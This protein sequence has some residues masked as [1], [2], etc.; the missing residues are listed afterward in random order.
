MVNFGGSAAGL[1]P[2][3]GAQPEAQVSGAFD[4]VTLSPY[5]RPRPP[6]LATTA[7]GEGLAARR[8]LRI[9]T[10][11]GVAL[12]GAVLL[13]AGELAVRPRRLPLRARGAGPSAGQPTSTAPALP[14]PAP[15]KS[16]PSPS[17]PPHSRGASKDAARRAPRAVHFAITAGVVAGLALGLAARLTLRRRRGAPGGVR[18]HASARVQQ[19]SG[20]GTPRGAVEEE[21]LHGLHDTFHSP[22]GDL[23]EEDEDLE[24]G[25]AEQPPPVTERVIRAGFTRQRSAVA[26][27]VKQWPPRPSHDP[28][29]FD[30]SDPLSKVSSAPT[31]LSLPLMPGWVRMATELS[32]AQ[33]LGGLSRQLT[34][35]LEKTH[36][37]QTTLE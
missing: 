5:V 31:T 15:A 28:E 19:A 14:A 32:E 23:K 9:R 20:A 21:K 12:G 22:A 26:D 1:G 2:A 4:L 10:L 37:R 16:G 36:S 34:L 13:G 17:S 29:V 6:G 3:R 35:A 18:P 27:A 25:G 30:I 24:A 8:A 33:D 7:P 11:R